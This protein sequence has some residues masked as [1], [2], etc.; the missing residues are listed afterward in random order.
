M[1][2]NLNLEQ[3]K[4]NQK[5]RAQIKNQIPMCLWLT[6][7]SGSGK[8][9]LANKLEQKL[10]QLGKHTY[11]LDGDNLRHGLNLD[12]GFTIDDRNENVRRT[13]EMAKLMVDA[14]LIVIVAIIS[15]FKKER[16]WANS[17]FKKNQFKEIYV[18]TA[19]AECENRDVK[20]LYKKARRGDIKD[21]TG[22]DSPYEPPENPTVSIDT[23]DKSVEDC[24]KY[25]LQKVYTE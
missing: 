17:L 8:S 10:Y 4:L 19:L 1:K 24:V 3:F 14:G 11:I 21:F 16:E 20:G 15:P 13:A 12:L 2:K 23:K 6:G 25:I 7:L 18:S 5:K 22:I 9:S